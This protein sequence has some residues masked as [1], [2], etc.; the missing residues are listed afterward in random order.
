MVA[1]TTPAPLVGVGRK[2]PDLD[3][4]SKSENGGESGH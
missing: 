3:K 2:P 4:E 1:L